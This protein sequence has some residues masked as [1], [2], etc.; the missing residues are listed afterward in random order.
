[1]S[2]GPDTPRR[3]RLLA[4]GADDLEDVVCAHL[5]TDAST[6]R[7]FG[8]RPLAR[9][10]VLVD[11]GAEDSP[12]PDLAVLLEAT[13]AGAAIVTERLGLWP[14]DALVVAPPRTLFRRARELAADT[15]RAAALAAAAR[16]A[17]ESA[18]TLGD[19]G[20]RLVALLDAAT[21]VDHRVAVRRPAPALSPAA[22][23]PAPR[24]IATVI[25][26]E[27]R[28]PDAAMLSGLDQAIRSVKALEARVERLET[29]EEDD[30]RVVHAGPPAD[31]PVQVSVL[32]PAHRAARTLTQTL[33]SVLAAAAEAGAPSLEVIV[34][35]DASPGPDAELAAAW[36]QAHPELPVT[37]LRHT[38]N[39]GLSAARNTAL[40]RAAGACVLPLDADDLLRPHG[41]PRLL[42]GLEADPEAVF[43]YGILE[44]FD[45]TGPTG[46]VGL[47][48][49]APE[50]LRTG[51]YIPALALI[52]REALLALGGYADM[53]WGYEDW[54]LW[55]RV[56]EA[57][58]HGVWVPQIVARYRTRANSMSANLHLTHVAPLADMLER[59]PVLL[60]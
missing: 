5:F 10:T 12:A 1:M 45:A 58:R 23:P 40:A 7:V 32:V 28:R 38:R 37:V 57:G 43:A 8:E 59:H 55:C 3:L 17:L 13:E 36:A 18:A 53:V 19:M 20:Q 25:R 46:L 34:V 48:P 22:S 56:A 50:R 52:R 49:W 31:G 15:T 51:N 60:A 11:V 47:Y 6:S 21:P 26:D 30:V 29:R 41:L 14:M 16:R 2:L 24:S 44:R 35:D 54:D 33:D 39:R 4:G 42:A 9:A 27:A